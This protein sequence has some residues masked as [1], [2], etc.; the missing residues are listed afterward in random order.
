MSVKPEGPFV[1]IKLSIPGMFFITV[2][3]QYYDFNTFSI[4]YQ[5]YILFLCP[6]ISCCFF[7]S[8]VLF[9]VTLRI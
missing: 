3:P 1:D 6:K 7:F 5:I 2:K 8:V 4:F 9:F